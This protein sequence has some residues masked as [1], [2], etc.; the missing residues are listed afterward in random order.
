MTSFGSTESGTGSGGG[1]SRGS[2][3]AATCAYLTALSFGYVIGY[4][5]PA[6]PDMIAHSTIDSNGGS[7]FASIMTIGG[8]LGSP[9]AGWI[10]EKLGRRLGLL[11]TTLPFLVGW[12]SI[13]LGGASA[14]TMLYFGRLM[15]GCGSGMACVVCSIYIAETSTKET[16]GTLGSGVQL[17]ITVGILLVYLLG[18]VFG[19]RGL[20]VIGFCIPFS[21]LLLVFRIPETPRWY[22]M[23]GRKA[24]ALR[25]LQ[26]LRRQ[27]Q[28]VEEELL[29]IEESLPSMDT[30]ISW[31]DFRKPELARPLHLV[32]GLMIIQQMS[33]INVIMFYLVSIF[34]NAGFKESGV[35]ATTIIAIVQVVATACA[36]YLMDRVGRRPL[37]IVAGIAMTVASA[38]LGWY[39]FAVVA[40]GKFISNMST[41]PLVALIL[42]I[43]GFS[44]GWGPIPVL[45]MSEIFPVKARG[46]AS[47]LAIITNW[48]C[49]FI[50]TKGYPIMTS[51]IGQHG[52]FWVFGGSTLLGTLFV[53]RFMPETKGKS[54]EDIELYF[55]GR[56][57]RGI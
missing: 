12:A 2:L 34:Y 23:H 26:A 25:S 31:K 15:T 45:V 30:A 20:A 44:I 53:M 57:V 39:Y 46:F 51:N 54:L 52:A 41:L 47:S 7:W 18:M 14:P 48:T 49:A 35:F 29:D 5:S 6:V 32:L 24:D 13:C 50:V 19:W 38:S 3:Q 1:Y 21:S 8:I 42:Y 17:A 55:L 40:D 4:S 10:I 22:M 27:G 9:L 37:L 33:G 36:V 11:I 16:R 56:A 43:V 28:N